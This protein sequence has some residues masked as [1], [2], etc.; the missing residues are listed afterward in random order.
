MPLVNNIDVTVTSDAGAIRDALYRQ[1]FGPV[2]WVESIQALKALGVTHIFECGP[3]K[4]L[5]GLVRRIDAELQSAA[6]FDP[7]SLAEA[8]A[9]L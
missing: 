4:V 2:R 7:A 8:R 1:A 6:V 5:S 9:M 3:G